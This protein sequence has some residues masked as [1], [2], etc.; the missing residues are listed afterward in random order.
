[1]EDI[2]NNNIENNNTNWNISDFDINKK[3]SEIIQ[4]LNISNNKDGIDLIFEQNPELI[5]TIINTLKKKERVRLYRIENKNIPYDGTREWIVSKKE[6]IGC[7]FTDNIQTLSNYIKKNQSKPWIELVY[8]DV[9]KDQLENF[10]VSNNK[11]TQTMDVENDNRIIPTTVNRNYSDLSSLSKVTGNF[12]SLKNV[13]QELN[14]IVSNLPKNQPI[15]NNQ[16][17]QIY[18]EYLTTIFPESKVKDILYHWTL[19][20]KFDVFKTEW[21][22]DNIWRLWAMAGSLKAANMLRG[23]QE[24]PDWIK[25][26]ER[27]DKPLPEGSF[28]FQLKFNLKNPY[29]AQSLDEAIKLNKDTLK[30]EWYDWVIIYWYE[31]QGNRLKE[32]GYG[33]EYVAFNSEQ[34]HI[35][36]FDK[37]IQQLKE[38]LNSRK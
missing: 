25:P 7:F 36:W 21:S 29:I 18:A 33:N 4:E 23:V 11:Y 15:N 19:N 30:K 2:L 38:W 34:I 9:P 32:T 20:G 31:I 13:Q 10:H 8:V 6:I 28:L 12:L 35:L 16:V 37:D 24:K 22:S 27:I 1:M 5:N 17:K 26:E 14:Q 3:K